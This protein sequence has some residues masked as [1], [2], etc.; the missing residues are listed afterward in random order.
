MTLA[1]NFLLES[2]ENKT[3]PSFKNYLEIN[4]FIL[5]YEKY[6]MKGLQ[7]ASVLEIYI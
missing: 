7:C 1:R 6:H 2:D 4:C 5:A 3:T